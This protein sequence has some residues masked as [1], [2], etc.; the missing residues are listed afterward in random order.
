[1][2]LFYNPLIESFVS[3]PKFSI[4]KELK[5]MYLLVVKTKNEEKQFSA[6]ISIQ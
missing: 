1:M 4:Q 6:K 5:G 3:T 2:S